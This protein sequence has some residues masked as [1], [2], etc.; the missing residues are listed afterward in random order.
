MCYSNGFNNSIVQYA[1]NEKN[2]TLKLNNAF[3]SHQAYII[4]CSYF[5]LVRK[6]FFVIH[7]RKQICM[8]TKYFIETKS[9]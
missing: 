4:P 6:L 2:N 3:A 9:L 8:H 1:S 5:T 7:Q